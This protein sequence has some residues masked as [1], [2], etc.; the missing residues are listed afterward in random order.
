MNQLELLWELQ[1]HE[2]H[3]ELIKEK[4]ENLA[5]SS[6]IETMTLKMEDLEQELNN[7]KKSLEENN[8]LLRKNDSTLKEL[9]YQLKEIEKELYSGVVTDIKQLDYM[10]KEGESIKDSI[11][12]LE[13]E[14]ISLMEDIEDIRIEIEKI[15]KE[16]KENKERFKETTIEYERLIDE[17]REQVRKDMDQIYNASSKIEKELYEKY[18]TIKNN[19][20]YAIAEVIED[21][22]SG[23]HVI[24]PTYLLDKV[25]DGEEIVQ[26][27]NCRRILFSPIHP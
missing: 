4:L 6:Y 7:R 24:I 20:R 10:D 2:K 18:N 23:C 16:H 22:C 8:K 13:L 5:K 9:N 15:E 3:L 27:E 17:L 21:E 1:E 26:C 25:K 12:E 14:I 19:K 11:N